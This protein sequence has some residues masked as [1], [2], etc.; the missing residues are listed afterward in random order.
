MPQDDILKYFSNLKDLFDCIRVTDNKGLDL[1]YID[2]IER[3]IILINSLDKSSNK[4][5]FIGNGASASISSHM[6][7][8]FWKNGG[9]PAIAFNDSSLLTC[10]S[11]DYG[12]P[13]VFEKPIEM[14]AKP[15]DILF[16]ISSSG[17]STNILNGTQAAIK[18]DCTIITF[19]GFDKNNPLSAMGDLNFYISSY[20]YGP[21]EI[22]HQAIVHCILDTLIG[23]KK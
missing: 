15:K 19:S 17:K 1:K 18:K 20:S 22:L 5:L 7:T 21:V 14:F 4:L 6:A 23:M 12:Y 10:I 11:N 2:G 8:D 9:I 16:A 3:S 13:F